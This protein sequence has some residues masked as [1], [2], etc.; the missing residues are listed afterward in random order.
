ME[1][2]ETNVHPFKLIDK[3]I[4][5]EKPSS[6]SQED[7]EK[8]TAELCEMI[9]NYEGGKSEAA[10]WIC[11]EVVNQASYNHYEALGILTETIMRYREVAIEVMCEEGEEE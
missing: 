8:K 9:K 6:V 10:E 4:D 11:F 3:K 7:I 2:K 1:K 5:E